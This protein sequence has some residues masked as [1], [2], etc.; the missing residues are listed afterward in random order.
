MKALS[1]ILLAGC[2][3]ALTACDG[4]RK[5][6]DGAKSKVEESARDVVGGGKGSA[7][8][9]GEIDP[10]WASL[11]D[12]NEEGILFRRDLPFPQVVSVRVSEKDPMNMRIVRTSDM[13]KQN[14]TDSS[15]REMAFSIR[16][17]QGTIT[18]ADYRE[19][20][21]DTVKKTSEGNP[22]VLNDHPLKSPNPPAEQSLVWKG[23]QW[24]PADSSTFAKVAYGRQV[25]PMVPDLLSEYG[26]VPRSMWFGKRRVQPGKTVVVSGEL[27]PML[28]AGD[29]TG[30]LS[31]TLQEIEAVH[32]HPCGK[33]AVRGSYKRRKFPLLDGRAFDE[34]VSIQSG[35][36]WLS[37]VYPLVLRYEWDRIVTLQIAEG[38]GPGVRCQGSSRIERMI[39]WKGDS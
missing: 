28:V 25:G 30:E 23:K 6:I 35:F 37:V 32:G 14:I 22:V 9:K 39:E 10:A 21:Q 36:V 33:F 11:I 26:L 27:L 34:E 2:C 31:L 12:R 29:A 38:S 19:L 1:T 24:Q 18:I 3:V 8:D 4:V 20:F 5:A 15:T 7:E 13:G 16:K 17:N